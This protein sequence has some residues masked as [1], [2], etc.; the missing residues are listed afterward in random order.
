MN[1]TQNL[2]KRAELFKALGHPTRLLI[3]NL[4]RMKPRHGEELAEILRLKPATISH[5][6]SKLSEVG[7]LS[8]KKDQ[9]YQVYSLI[10]DLLDTPLGEMITMPQE[11]L[12]TEV[13]EDAYTQKVLRTFIKHGQLKQFPAQLKKRL[14]VLKYVLE[15]FEFDKQYSEREVNQ[16]LVS[17]H[18]DVASL[19]RGFIEHKLMARDKGMYWRIDQEEE[20]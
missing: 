20:A 9:Y 14:I 17:F 11:G 19:R 8:A 12:N 6:L 5:H 2:E 1:A 7:L 18:E 16:I 4:I 13:K 10:P 3:V 15:E